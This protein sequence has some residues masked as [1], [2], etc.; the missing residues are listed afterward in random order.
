MQLKA[1]AGTWGV[2]AAIGLM[3]CSRDVQ[4]QQG[5]NGTWQRARLLTQRLP[6]LL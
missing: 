1:Q 3:R 4:Q 6:L 2:M 5:N